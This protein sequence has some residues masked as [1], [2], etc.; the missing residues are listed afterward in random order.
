[1]SESLSAIMPERE[2]GSLLCIHAYEA[3][4]MGARAGVWDAWLAPPASWG[5][6]IG[7][8]PADTFQ[9][10]DAAVQFHSPR[11]G[12]AGLGALIHVM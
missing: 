8:L 7:S 1:M 10:G 3:W 4:K 6:Q 11:A 5:G 2:K 9:L 12:R